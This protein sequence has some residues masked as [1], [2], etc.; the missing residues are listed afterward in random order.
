MYFRKVT[1]LRAAAGIDFSYPG[2]V[3]A[4]TLPLGSETCE[5]PNRADLSEKLYSSS[6]QSSHSPLGDAR[7]RQAGSVDCSAEWVRNV[8]GNSVR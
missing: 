2:G 7:N 5:T 1:T 4:G 6:C 8:E 3:I